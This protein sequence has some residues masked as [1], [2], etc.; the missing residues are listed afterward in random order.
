MG[1]GG[2]GASRVAARRKDRCVTLHSWSPTS[3][4]PTRSPTIEGLADSEDSHADLDDLPDVCRCGTHARM[5][6]AIEAGAAA[7]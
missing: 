7:M 5:R 1:E 3:V 4:R 6:E 2:P